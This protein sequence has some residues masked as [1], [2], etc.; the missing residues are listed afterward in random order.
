MGRELLTEEPFPTFKPRFP[1]IGRDLQTLRNFFTGARSHIGGDSGTRLL[2]PMD[3]NTGDEL[4]GVLTR[5]KRAKEKYPLIVLL[6]G[7]SGCEESVYMIESTK[8][9]SALGYHVLRLNLR[10]SVPTQPV[11]SQQY[12]AGRVDDLDQV[13]RQLS[14]RGDLPGVCVVIGFSLGGNMLLKFL[15]EMGERHPIR[16]AVSVSSPINLAAAS[17]R[18][19]QPRNRLYH[20]WII[21]HMKRDALAQRGLSPR[22]A[23]AVSNART[24]YEFDDR[25]VAPRNGFRDARDYYSRCSAVHYL[26]DI[27]TPT[28]VIHALDDPWIPAHS[29]L[30]FNWS[31]NPWLTPLLPLAGGHLGFHA[32]N[33]TW[34]NRV[35]GMFFDRVVNTKSAVTPNVI[36]EN[37]SSVEQER[38]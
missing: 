5:P 29:Y 15:A 28:L 9:F 10:G 32:K 3:D 35:A 25:V 31:S 17:E 11:C 19:L 37:D 18:F 2:F 36:I 38:I 7:L 26:K 8:Y 34:H 1:W 24:I 21:Q 20:R 12:H 14:S 4:N 22:E 23:A 27:R 13:L 30:D 33:G 6:H 16:A